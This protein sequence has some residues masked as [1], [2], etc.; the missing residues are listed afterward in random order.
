MLKNLGINCLAFTVCIC[1]YTLLHCCIRSPRSPPQLL[2]HPLLHPL[3]LF[4]SFFAPALIVLLP[5]SCPVPSSALLQHFP[6]PA[7]HLPQSCSF[8]AIAQPPSRF[9]SLHHH[10]HRFF[11]HRTSCLLLYYVFVHRPYYIVETMV[12][13][14]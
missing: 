12:L 13:S 11:Q 4:C 1:L 10:Q 5:S 2:L 8:P 14:Y 7:L 9:D 6:A 3:L